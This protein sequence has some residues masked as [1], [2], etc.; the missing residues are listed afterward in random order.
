M[1]DELTPEPTPS[2]E[3]RNDL[4]EVPKAR[5]LQRLIP[6]TKSRQLIAIGSIVVLLGGIT[7]GA[8]TVVSHLNQPKQHFN[9]KQVPFMIVGTTPYSGENDLTS[10]DQITIKFNKPIDPTKLNGDFWI[11]PSVEGRFSQSSSD[12]ATF[13]P[14]VP[15]TQGV[16]YSVMV[17]G[18][19]A[20]KSGDR[21]GSDYNFS[22]ITAT[23]DNTVIFTT[24]AARGTFGS[25]PVGK[26]QIYTLSAGSSVD[27]KGVVNVYK[28]SQIDLLNALK[29]GGTSGISGDAG[30][31]QII[32]QV[33]TSGMALVQTQPGIS[34]GSTVKVNLPQGIYVL[35]AQSSNLQYGYTWLVVTDLAVALRQDDLKI[36]LAVSQ[37]SSSLSTQA[38]VQIYNFAISPSPLSDSIIDGVGAIDSPYSQQ[39]QWAVV[40]KDDDIA[41]VPINALYSLA[42]LR[43]DQDLN[44]ATQA[45]GLTDKPTY[46]AGEKLRFSGFVYEDNDV[47][48]TPLTQTQVQVYVAN[49]KWGQHLADA[50]ITT[51]ADG[52]ISGEFQVGSNWISDGN[53][54]GLGIYINDSS[55]DL[56]WLS[57]SQL[58]TFTVE[59]APTNSADIQVTFPQNEYFAKDAITTQ[60]QAQ[61]KNG[62]PL[63]NTDI[64]VE[65]FT[66][67]YDESSN[68]MPRIISDNPGAAL[69]GFP[70]SV[71]LDAQGKA[72][73]PIDSSTFPT[74][75]SQVLVIR[76]SIDGDS[77]LSSAASISSVIV[78]Q[79]MGKIVFGTITGIVAPGGTI[80]AKAY[81]MTLGNAP[82]PNAQFHYTLSGGQQAPD[83]TFQEVDLASGSATAD[84]NGYVEF[85]QSLGNYGEDSQDSGNLTLT[86]ST[87]DANNDI[88][89]ASTNY[90]V[91]NSDNYQVHSDLQLDKFSISGS[92]VNVSVG[93]T[94]NLVINVPND[95]H[96]LITLDRGRIYK[97]DAVD[98]KQGD[99]NYQV[100]VTPDMLP[101]FNISFTYY[102]GK[103]FR[104][105]GTT[106]NVS[107]A[108]RINSISITPN[109]STY[110]AGDIAK[111]QINAQNSTGGPAYSDLIIGVVNENMYSLN[112]Q[113]VVS[114]SSLY[115]PREMT[116]TSSDSL[117]GMGS[118]G[119]GGCGP[120]GSGYDGSDSYLNPTGNSIYWDPSAITTSDGNA[121]FNLKLPKGTW[122]VFV[123]SADQSI[124]VGS[125]YIDVAAK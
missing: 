101:G 19:F 120:G 55:S 112:S 78:H 7:L 115:G 24:N 10:V 14:T 109:K 62:K 63:S 71:T 121:Q 110:K 76:A 60:I 90:Y 42:D 64:W 65:A 79:G 84:A 47:H 44:K 3:S 86:L 36:V 94:L 56:D 54:A 75:S 52:R 28:A 85:S 70:L 38:R 80:T 37:F 102:D 69:D 82:I 83:G 2:D 13:T 89:E 29:S 11:K 59:K 41:V 107:T 122:R 5:L 117:T 58:A 53:S 92:S 4:P 33:D 35:T 22:F 93:Q 50:K 18:E 74:G 20:S 91:E 39:A 46:I 77:K 32:S 48:Y 116:I 104:V 97:Y 105:E 61:D 1:S 81:A 119:F 31:G 88:I 16:E 15:L 25:S 66:T 12:Q 123:Y 98:F 27:P 43:A 68:A 26:D 108:P 34:D 125:S 96:A 67:P 99:N 30:S 9:K 100:V 72:T 21:L 17:H 87:G 6:Q 8:V 111:F 114:M 23:P 49:A 45:F 51:D 106:F 57:G 103:I 118:A 40:S 95:I 124:D 113:P 73:V